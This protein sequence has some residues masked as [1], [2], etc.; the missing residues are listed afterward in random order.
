MSVTREK[1]DLPAL[2]SSYA[3]TFTTSRLSL[4]TTYQPAFQF[5]VIRDG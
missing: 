5:R 1:I 2:P 4:S 3:I